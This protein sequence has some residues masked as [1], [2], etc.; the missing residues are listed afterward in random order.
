ML[1]VLVGFITYVINISNDNQ[2]EFRNL[3]WLSVTEYGATYYY[4]INSE[5]TLES[6]VGARK[7]ESGIQYVD[8]MEHVNQKESIKLKKKNFQQ[9]LKFANEVKKSKEKEVIVD[10]SDSNEIDLYYQ[11]HIYKVNH[12]VEFESL[13]NLWKEIERLAPIKPQ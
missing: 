3:V 12:P 2:N 13:H 5:R 6:S 11:G 7:K 10:I 4:V 8:Y 9:I 1:F